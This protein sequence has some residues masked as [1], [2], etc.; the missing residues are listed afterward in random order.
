MSDSPRD[1]APRD[2]RRAIANRCLSAGIAAA[3][4]DQVVEDHVSISEV[5]DTLSLRSGGHTETIDLSGFDQ[6]VLLGGG[7]AAS[8]VAREVEAILGD[9]LAAGIVVTDDPVACDR[10]TVLA[11]GHPLPTETGVESATQV[12]DRVREADERTLILAVVTGGAS[13][14]LAVPADGIPVAALRETTTALLESGATIDEI[15]AV[16]KHLSAIK[17]GRLAAAAAPATVRAIVL[18]DVVGND[19]ATIGSGPFAPDPTT[20]ADAL[21]V[22]EQYD[23]SVPDVVRSHLEAGAT[24]SHSETPKPGANCFD[25]VRT[26][27][28][29]DGMT[30]MR[31][32]A[33]VAETAGYEPLLLSARIRGEAREAAK[34]AVGIAEESLAS[35]MP[36]EPPAAI[37]S[38][39][40]TTVTVGSTIGRDQ[41]TTPGAAG[42]PNQEFA[43]SAAIEIG[44]QPI[45]VGAID[46]D[47]IDGPTDAA[48]AIVDEA[49][50]SASG[51][52]ER[53]EPTGAIDRSKA[54]TAL[55]E[56]RSNAALDAVDALYRCGPT[57]TNVNDL[58]VVL[59]ETR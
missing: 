21:A 6:I 29:A 54:I 35:G 48:G 31:A 25:R 53:D 24:G 28:I 38:G 37:V 43:L 26:H 58:R 9:R 32:A 39:G 59:V 44:E 56:H 18:S 41:E 45:T 40:E 52:T 19:L 15:N 14:V 16:R 22:L 12:L 46:T 4:P 51:S 5:D 42:G 27:V 1:D 2:Q 36:I 13:A 17:G 55:R 10:T 30:A 8:Q 20:Y 50:V 34:T 47:G 23:L 7:N 11:G 33:S 49:T 3:H 57:G